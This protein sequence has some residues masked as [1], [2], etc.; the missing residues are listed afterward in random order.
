[1]TEHEV[2]TDELAAL[3]RSLDA[4]ADFIASF[5]SRAL[6]S[7][8]ALAAQWSGRAS[9]EFYGE[10]ATWVQG[11]K[12][13]QSRAESIAAWAHGANDLYLASVEHSKGVVGT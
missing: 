3:A 5:E 11:A 9:L 7:G 6:S 12:A 4:F 2:D 13:V 8:H 10:L 1:M